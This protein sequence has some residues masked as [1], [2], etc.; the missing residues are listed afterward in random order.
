MTPGSA[1]RR[2]K[3]RPSGAENR[4]PPVSGSV[5]KISKSRRANGNLV[6]LGQT[7]IFDLPKQERFLYSKSLRH[8][9][10]IIASF[11][12][13]RFIFCRIRIPTSAGA[14]NGDGTASRKW[15][16]N[17]QFDLRYDLSIKLRQTT[18]NLIYV[19][20]GKEIHAC[21]CRVNLRNTLLYRVDIGRLRN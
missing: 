4:A 3:R 10:T 7:T 5:S 12:L 21:I 13:R 15:S 18:A 6:G 1:P 17:R 9:K 8:K 11:C 19:P 16:A 14:V 2:R 20:H